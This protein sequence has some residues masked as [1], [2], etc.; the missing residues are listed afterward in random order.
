[1]PNWGVSALS[2]AGEPVAAGVTVGE[3]EGA[4]TPPFRSTICCALRIVNAV[5]VWA[6][7]WAFAMCQC[8]S[9]YAT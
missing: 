2:G 4:A 1:M 8:V 7:V 5:V 9:P 6:C 3:G